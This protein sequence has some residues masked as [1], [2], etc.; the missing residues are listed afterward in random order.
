MVY[1]IL[2]PNS[3]LTS[4]VELE[5]HNDRVQSGSISTVWHNKKQNKILM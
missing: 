1:L 2:Q 5:Q 3:W 4:F